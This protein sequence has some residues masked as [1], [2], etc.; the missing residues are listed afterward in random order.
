MPGCALAGGRIDWEPR[1]VTRR[2][3]SMAMVAAATIL[4]FLAINAHTLF[5][6]TATSTTTL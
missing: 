6:S 1:N 2:L 5:A 3:I 4:A